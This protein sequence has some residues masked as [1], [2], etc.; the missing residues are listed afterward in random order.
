MMP[1]VS[2]LYN[3]FS[4]NLDLYQRDYTDVFMCPLCLRV[5]R[6]D[7][8]R[9][10]LSKAH[11]IP[12]F[13]GGREWTL[14]CRQ[15]NNRVGSEIESYEKERASFHWALLGD[16]DETT[17]VRSK[18]RKKRG[19]AIG[20]VQADM[21]STGSGADRRLRLDLQPKV[22][23]PNAYQQLDDDLA[24]GRGSWEFEFRVTRS[25]KRAD[26]TYV[27]A[28]Y[29]QMF[30]QFGY[31]WVFS[32]GAKTIREQI[33]SPDEPIFRPMYPSLQGIH[34]A[35]SEL[36]VLLV[37][38]PADWC[39]FLV[40]LPLIRGQ[41]GRHAMWMPLF[42]CPYDQPPARKGVQL[43]VVHVPDHHARLHR[44]DSYMQGCRFAR[45]HLAHRA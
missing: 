4:A 41:A 14:T 29:L 27:H 24:A 3:T 22:S 44:S 1:S 2:E 34:V 8:V 38:E 26:L 16:G 5:F 39:H 42:G 28:A 10:D 11:I 6:R 23:N 18:V 36:A 31:E 20:P 37:T 12:Q 35:D 9:S 33:T 30:H 19:P 40:V 32:P 25:P 21:R 45:H 7:Q 15:C 43:T 17:R 13:L